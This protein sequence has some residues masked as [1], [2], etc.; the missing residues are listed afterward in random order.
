MY[1]AMSLRFYRS[2]PEVFDM[3]TQYLYE[4]IF[5]EPFLRSF[6]AEKLEAMRQRFYDRYVDHRHS[7]IRLTEAQDPFF[8]AVPE[9]IEE[10]RAVETP[11]L[12][13]AGSQDRAI[14]LWHQRGLLAVFPNA[15]MELVEGCGHVAYMEQPAAFFG[16][17][18]SFMA[19]KSI[20]FEVP[21]ELAGMLVREDV[22]S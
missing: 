2:T 3:Y 20:G 19:A 1:E 4:K 16:I 7:L 10:Y 17:M 15:R 18:K 5:G 14:P 12:I 22:R 11:V 13:L 9:R 21:P 8:A 6:P